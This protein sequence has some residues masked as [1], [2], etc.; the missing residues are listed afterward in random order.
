MPSNGPRTNVAERVVSE[1]DA[2]LETPL[3]RLADRALFF[4][5]FLSK[6]RIISSAVPSS[7]AL[8]QGMLR[9]VD[10]SRPATIVELGAGIGPVTE[11]VLARLEP[12]H[13]FVAVENDPE[14]CEVL[15]RRFPNLWLLECDATRAGAQL[16]AQG[17]HRVDYV[18]SGLPT[19]SLPRRAAV[20]LCR[21]LRRA[22]AP[23]G[24]FI[25]ITVA[26]LVFRAFYDRLFEQVQYRMVWQNVPPGGVYVCSQPR[27]GHT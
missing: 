24:L 6:G 21:W 3:T 5:K 8:V 9:P 27:V 16:A 19:P 15:R 25:Q 2:A 12:H 18:L 20:R 14:F 22:L 23:N 10:F 7:R 13:R 26:P 17:V 1:T 4:R 11:E